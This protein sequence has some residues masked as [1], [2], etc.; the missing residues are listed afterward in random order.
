MKQFILLIFFTSIYFA[1]NAQTFAVINDKDGFV[2]VRKDGNIQSPIVGKLLLDDVFSYDDESKSNWV[3]IIKQYEDENHPELTG[4][5][6]KSRILPLS[7]LKGINKVKL[8][9][10]SCVLNND[11]ISVVVSSSLF[12]SKTH[13]L[14]YDRTNKKFPILKKI[15]NKIF[16]GT[17]GESPKK[18]ISF[19][20]FSKNGSPIVIPSTAYNDLY[21]PNLKTLHVYFGRSN[22]FYIQM[23]NSDGAGG[24]S[25]V[26]IIK[27][28]TFY[29]RYVDNS[30]A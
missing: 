2:N 23:D 28:N 14:T 15:D 30:E 8:F 7:K 26:W 22:T 6:S 24:Y 1:S 4:Y 20:K 25:V 11:S 18:I 5:I 16:W 19:I 10:D 3:E 21:E 9:K 27:N 17:D 29:K 13:T 12:T